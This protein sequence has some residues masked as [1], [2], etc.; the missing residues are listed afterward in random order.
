MKKKGLIPTVVI[1]HHPHH[2]EKQKSSRQGHEH[3]Q[4]YYGS[5][6]NQKYNYYGGKERTKKIHRD[7]KVATKT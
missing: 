3:Q 2:I 1:Y 5:T 4:T 7:I 6:W